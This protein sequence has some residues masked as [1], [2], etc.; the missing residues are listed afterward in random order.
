MHFELIDE[1]L[2]TGTPPKA[3]VIKDLLANPSTLAEAAPVYEG[4]KMLGERTP[5]LALLA[6]RLVLAGKRADDASVV[7]LRK[8]AEQARAG[9]AGALEA[10]EAYARALAVLLLICASMLLGAGWAWAQTPTPSPNV[11]RSLDSGRSHPAADI[12]GRIESVDYPGGTLNVRV[13][14]KTRVVAVTPSTT[15]YQHGGYATFADLR[16]GQNCDISV[17]EV[18]GRLVAQI[19]RI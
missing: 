3:R 10:R 17:Y 14:A 16:R 8:H 19:I 1:Y 4:M 13:G 18:A 11:Y 7:T 15:I 9:G 2:L 6:L 12:H 5:D